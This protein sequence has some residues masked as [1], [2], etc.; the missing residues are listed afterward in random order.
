LFGNLGEQ[1]GDNLTTADTPD[2]GTDDPDSGHDDSSGEA[3]GDT[4][5]A[6][7]GTTAEPA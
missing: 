7:Q 3:V 2:S 1:A 5:D 6:G 4:A